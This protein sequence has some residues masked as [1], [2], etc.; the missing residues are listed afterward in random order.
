MPPATGPLWAYFHQSDT[1]PNGNHFRATH[2]H[3][4]DARHP[5]DEPID[6]DASVDV[7]LIKNAEWFAEALASAI[8]GKCDVNGE[9]KAMAGHLRRC[10]HSTAAEKARAAEVN[11]TKAEKKATESEAA[12]HAREATA[13]DA[14]DEAPV[15]SGRKK[16]KLVKAVEKSFT[17][18]KLEVFKGLDIPFSTSQ[19]EAIKAQFLRATQ[20]ANLPEMWTSDP[21]VLKLF[22]MFR[23]RAGDVIPSHTQLGG[24]APEGC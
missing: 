21:E 2:W 8:E 5:Q 11:P 4:I 14:D 10:A 18:S 17:Q 24:V 20:S 16:R 3:C 22:M 23:S 7:A 9:K 1:K 19:T 6:V 12:K 15:T 13:S